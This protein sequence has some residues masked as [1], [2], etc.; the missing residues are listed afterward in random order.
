MLFTLAE[1]T[2][3]ET[4]DLFA[5]LQTSLPD[6]EKIEDQFMAKAQEWLNL[7]KNKD[8]ASIAKRIEQIKKQLMETDRDYE[9]SYK[10]MYKMLESTEE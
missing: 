4:P 8:S 3:Q 9:E 5:R 6:L 2:A 1:S 7:I 10:T